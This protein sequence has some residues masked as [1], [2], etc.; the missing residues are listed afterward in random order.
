[1]GVIIMVNK[2]TIPGCGNC[3]F[4]TGICRVMFQKNASKPS[5]AIRAQID[6]PGAIEGPLV[7][8]IDGLVC[9]AEGNSKLQETCDRFVSRTDNDDLLDENI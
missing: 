8:T 9:K 1:M 5:L 7:Q 4:R 3:N 2:E 6:P